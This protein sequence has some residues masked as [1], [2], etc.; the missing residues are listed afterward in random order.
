MWSIST[1]TKRYLSRWIHI[2]IMKTDE[3][4][5]HSKYDQEFFNF[6]LFS[7][8][9]DC[10]MY[11]KASYK[12]VVF[13]FLIPHLSQIRSNIIIYTLHLGTRELGFCEKSLTFFYLLTFGFYSIKL[14][15][16]HNL[17]FLYYMELMLESA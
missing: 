14:S 1:E 11:H 15:D 16:A 5:M 7:I 8:S 9:K 3:N 13:T 12:Y 17:A 10:F 2:T 6:I 4:K